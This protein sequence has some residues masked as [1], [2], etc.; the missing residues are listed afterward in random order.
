MRILLAILLILSFTTLTHSQT[1]SSLLKTLEPKDNI[2][3]ARDFIDAL[4]R[5]ALKA[6]GIEIS[7]CIDEDVEIIEGVKKLVFLIQDGLVNHMEE[8]L[9]EFINI[10]VDIPSALVDCEKVPEEIKKFI[11]LIYIY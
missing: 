5:T 6:E 8:I 9:L 4:L 2:E 11:K 10:L 3:E 7:K 1:V